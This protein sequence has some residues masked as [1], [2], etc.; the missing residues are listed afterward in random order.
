MSA[1]PITLITIGKTLLD[2]KDS[3]DQAKLEQERYAARRE[4]ARIKAL[5]D[6]AD[7]RD[8]LRK[9]QAHNLAI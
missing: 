6:E 2:I 7:R 1:D 3:K 5:E 8:M 4:A 9:Q